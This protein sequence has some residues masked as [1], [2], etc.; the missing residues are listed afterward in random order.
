MRDQSRR[1]HRTPP[2]DHLMAMLLLLLQNHSAARS[3]PEL[4]DVVTD[5]IGG[6]RAG[7]P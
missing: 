2:A 1:N 4:A 3:V 6:R 5:T 7:A